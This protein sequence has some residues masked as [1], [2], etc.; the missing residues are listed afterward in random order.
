LSHPLKLNKYNFCIQCH[1]EYIVN[2]NRP[3]PAVICRF[4]LSAKRPIIGRPIPIIG[5]L[6][7]HP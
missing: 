4:R 2:N 6:S 3:I 5:R 7:V 1:H